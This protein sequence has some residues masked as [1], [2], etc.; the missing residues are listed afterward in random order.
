MYPENYLILKEDLVKQWIAEG[1]IVEGKS[2]AKVA[3][4][5]FDVLVSLGLI[6]QMDIECSK[7]QPRKEKEEGKYDDDP[8]EK[9]VRVVEVE[10]EENDA[11]L[12]SKRMS[13]VVHPTVYE[14]ITCKSMEDNFITAIDYSQ[15]NV[16][17]TERTHRLSLQFGSATYAVAPTS[18]TSFHGTLELHAF[19]C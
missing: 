14:F 3:G 15:S 11:L 12:H 18:I 6:Q 9:E 17:L 13:Y 10:E 16:A 19:T 5:Y 1:F 4:S 2:I 8:K 7:E